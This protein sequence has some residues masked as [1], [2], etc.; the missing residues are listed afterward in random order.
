MLHAE[1]RVVGAISSADLGVEQPEA[2]RPDAPGNAPTRDDRHRGACRIEPNPS[3][4]EDLHPA[5]RPEVKQP[6]RFQEKLAFL[7]K[8]QI[9]PRQIHLLLVDFHLREIRVVGE[10]G[11]QALR[12]P[13]LGVDAPVGVAV[14]RNS[15]AH[16]AI[17]GEAGQDVRLQFQ[18]LSRRRHL[19]SHDDAIGL[20]AE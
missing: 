16:G 14:V 19:E 15:R 12:D 3:R 5:R 7:G 4:V 17:R 8:E 10:V 18:I 11:G 2:P 20:P 9:E 1:H 6:T 13:V